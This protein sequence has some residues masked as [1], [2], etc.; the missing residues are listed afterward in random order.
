MTDDRMST[1]EAEDPEAEPDGPAFR[2]KGGARRERKAPDRKLFDGDRVADGLKEWGAVVAFAIVV[3]VFSWL[4]PSTFPTWRN[5]VNV[6]N[7]SAPL[8][9]FATVAT[10]ALI[11]GEFDLSFPAVADFVSV[12]VGVL[13]TTFAWSSQIGIIGALLVGLAVGVAIGVANGLL[14]AKAFV[15]SFIAT[16]AVGSITTGAELAAQGWLRGGA[17]QIS[18]VMLPAGVQA[19]GDARIPGVDLKWTFAI[20]LLVAGGAWVWTRRSVAGRRSYAIG[21]NAVGAYLAG[22]PVARLRILGFVVIGALSALVG[23]MTL[24]ERGY[25]YFASPPLMLQAYSSAFLGAAVLTRKRRFDILASVFSAFFL[26]TLSNGLS[27]M[28]QPRWIGSVI[29]GF[30]LLIAV[31]ANMPK[32]RK[33]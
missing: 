20:A 2:P 9:L 30:I 14:I 33:V 16:L 21:G 28:N 7:N 31:F 4:L 18:Q 25:F 23:V 5:A 13:V 12:L 26:L 24:T 6:L 17:R 19:L 27:L 3:V 11:V 10:T 32:N 1:I 8:V 15:P 22:V 29:S